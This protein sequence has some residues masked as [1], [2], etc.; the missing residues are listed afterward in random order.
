MNG[1]TVSQVIDF[2]PLYAGRSNS[3]ENPRLPLND[4]DAWEAY[5]LLDPSDAGAGV[6]V[7][8]RRALGYPPWWR[9]V[10]LISASVARLPLQIWE[11]L[12]EHEQRKSIGHPS[13]KLLRRK[14]SS[15]LT[16]FQFKRTLQSHALVHGNGYA[17][18][19]RDRRTG[20]ALELLILNPKTTVP[21]MDAGVLWYAVEAGDYKR[22]LRA[23]DVLHIRGMGFDGLAGYP[24][25][26]VMAGALSLG[27]AA[28]EFGSKFFKNGQQASGILML[29]AGLSKEAAERLQKGWDKRGKGLNNAF[30]TAVLEEG[31]KWQAVTVNPEA[32]QTLET[33][34]FE[35]KEVA[36]ILCI[37]PHKLGAESQSSY[38]SLEQENLSYLIDCLDPWLISWEEECGDKLL[39]EQQLDEDTHF[40]QFNRQALAT[41]DVQTET[42]RLVKQVESGVMSLDAGRSFLSLPPLADGNGKKHRLPLNTTFVE[43]VAK[44][45]DAGSTSGDPAPSPAT[46]VDPAADVQAQALNGAQ[47]QSLA[48][49]IAQVTAGAMP[50]ETARAMIAASFPLLTVVQIAA[51]VDPLTDFEPKPAPSAT[52]PAPS[53]G[54]P[55]LP[56]DTQAPTNRLHAAR[57]A[58]VNLLTDRLARMAK[59]AFAEYGRKNTWEAKL[60]DAID[61]P[62]DVLAALAGVGPGSASVLAV[63]I[64]E[65]VKQRWNSAAG[66]V[67]C[68]VTDAEAAVA[69]DVTRILNTIEGKQ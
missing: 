48:E 13:Y 36:N 49:I 42:D 45:A 15:T 33:R 38:G 17:A 57:T 64:A 43:D 59:I 16:A 3:I 40:V 6:R 52:P 26:E 32:A 51:I 31:A 41:V 5:G 39:T 56:A 27:I 25:L 23:E 8:E 58:A 63:E 55:T 69:K 67:L 62:I 1:P 66:G 2:G 18:I 30:K 61:G 12:G 65:R 4:A 19:I 34:Q 54:D 35:V 14:P 28:R 53:A 44:P 20:A 29:P 9:G 21:V 10:N 46:P 7:T 60:L 37:P 68:G 50:L 24:V 22:R 11:R 47:V